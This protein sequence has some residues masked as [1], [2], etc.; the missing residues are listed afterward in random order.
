MEEIEGINDS[1]TG[2]KDWEVQVRPGVRKNRCE[3]GDPMEG[4]NFTTNKKGEG[5]D[6]S[7]QNL[8]GS[9]FASD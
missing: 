1:R 3:G 7:N 6:K 4:D 2:A 9:K 8:S 5:K